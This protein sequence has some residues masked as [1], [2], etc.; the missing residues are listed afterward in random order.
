M[1]LFFAVDG[2]PN[3]ILVFL[4]GLILILIILFLHPDRGHHSVFFINSSIVLVT[5][6]LRFIILLNFKIKF[7]NIINVDNY[8]RNRNKHGKW[9]VAAIFSVFPALI[10]LASLIQFLYF[11]K[12]FDDYHFTFFSLTLSGGLLFA[13]DSVWAFRIN[14]WLVNNCL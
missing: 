14:T 7:S 10:F 8:I 12:N 1:F 3:K 5:C 13:V 4:T 9:Y 11:I 6:F 2:I